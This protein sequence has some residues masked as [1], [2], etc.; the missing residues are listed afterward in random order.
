MV[1]TRRALRSVF[2]AVGTPSMSSS[3]PGRSNVEVA[4]EPSDS[5]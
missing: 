4:S 1:A 5:S 2:P 3:L